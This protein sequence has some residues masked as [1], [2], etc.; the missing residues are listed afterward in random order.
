MSA[1]VV[2]REVGSPCV[3]CVFTLVVMVNLVSG[4]YAPAELEASVRDSLFTAVSLTTTT[5]FVTAD[6]EVWAPGAQMVLFGLL[7]VGGMA[8]S[9]GGGIKSVRVLLLLKQSAME[10][11]KHLHPRAVL[12]ARVGR[13]V[14]PEN[15][16]ANVIGFVILYLL[17]FLAGATALCFLAVATLPLLNHLGHPERA[18]NIVITPH[19]T[20]AICSVPSVWTR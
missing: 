6:Y 8:G 9:T 14:V 3:R 7:F 15:V 19:F 11:R 16:L 5:G 4:T 10:L 2:A 20:S 18:A 13:H 17:I 12:L 1:A